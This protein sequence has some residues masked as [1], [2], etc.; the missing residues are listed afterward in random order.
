MNRAT[1]EA[2]PASEEGQLQQH[3]EA[4]DEATGASTRARDPGGSPNRGG[5]ALK[6]IPR[7]GKARQVDDEVGD[8]P[9][10]RGTAVAGDVHGHVSAGACRRTG[11]CP[12]GYRTT[13]WTA[14]WRR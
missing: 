6:T 10:D 8:P 5:R 9:G 2:L 13:G 4:G 14:A 12:S 1:G 7:L 3:A 11:C